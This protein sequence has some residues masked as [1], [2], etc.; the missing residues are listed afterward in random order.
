MIK[1]V[2]T[3]TLIILI[4]L[5]VVLFVCSS[6]FSYYLFT[7][8]PGPSFPG[9]LIGFVDIGNSK[10][11]PQTILKSVERGDTEY[12]FLMES[13]FPKDPQFI[14]P[15]EWTQAEFLKVAMSVHQIV[16]GE[17][18]DGWNLYRMDFRTN[19]KDNPKGLSFAGF[20]Y[21]KETVVKDQKTY[22]LR[23]IE[24][25]PEH[26]YITWGSENWSRLF[27]GSW[28]VIDLDKVI[29]PVEKALVTAETRGGMDF[30]KSVGNEC[31]IWI[32]MIPEAYDRNDW[33]VRYDSHEAFWIPSK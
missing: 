29:F 13:D 10:I 20:Y 9:T 6:I 26:S 17:T 5:P 19:C 30:R 8:E 3:K 27:W 11:D 33:R 28:K 21:Y 1:R 18:L 14:M 22:L 4:T 24:I 15:I 12:L 7:S 23:G 16:W 2:L 25:D 31:R 32:S